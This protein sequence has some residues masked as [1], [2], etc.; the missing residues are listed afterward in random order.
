MNGKNDR[1]RK[2]IKDNIHKVSSRYIFINITNTQ[3][4]TIAGE[5]RTRSLWKHLFFL[6]RKQQ[7]ILVIMTQC[8]RNV[9]HYPSPTLTGNI[10]Y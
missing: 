4:P 9:F 7:P 5:P 3:L 2:D 1:P 10:L 6:L 8:T